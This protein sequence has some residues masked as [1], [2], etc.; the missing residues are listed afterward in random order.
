MIPLG[1]TYLSSLL[2]ICFVWEQEKLWVDTSGGSSI[3]PLFVEWCI[4]FNQ[5]Q[6]TIMSLSLTVKCT[7]R[8]LVHLLLGYRLSAVFD[9]RF[10]GHWFIVL[11]YSLCLWVCFGL[12]RDLTVL[13]MQWC[14]SLFMWWYY[15]FTRLSMDTNKWNYWSYYCRWGPQFEQETYKNRQRLYLS[16]QARWSFHAL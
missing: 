13:L 12:F 9:C 7:G 4:K 10:F 15:F 16:D 3:F 8:I 2:Y 11:F 5:T 6:P 1:F 14:F